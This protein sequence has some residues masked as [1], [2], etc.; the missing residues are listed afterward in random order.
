MHSCVIGSRTD[1]DIAQPCYVSAQVVLESS[2]FWHGDRGCNYEETGNFATLG[3]VKEIISET[4]ALLEALV[5]AL[6][7]DRR[8]VVVTP[9]QLQD[10]VLFRIRVDSRDLGKVIGKQGRIA[11]SLRVILAAIAKENRTTLLLDVD[12]S[13]IGTS[14]ISAGQACPPQAEQVRPPL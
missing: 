1:L 9:Q 2:T 11:R 3:Y 10:G 13:E 7:T 5:A 12:A 4:G 14:A 8:A 6:V